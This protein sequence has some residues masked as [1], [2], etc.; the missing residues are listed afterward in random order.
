MERIDERDFYPE[1]MEGGK[2]DEVRFCKYYLRDNPMVYVDGSF[3]DVEGRI[4]D[5]SEIRR[6]I[7]LEISGFVRSGIARK[8]EAILGTMRY[9]CG[10]TKL[11]NPLK[12][13]HVKNGT[14]YLDWKFYESKQICRCRLPVEFHEDAPSPECWLRFVNEL[15]EPEDVLTLQE[16][17]GYCLIPTTVAQKM[18]IITGRGGEGKSRIG[19]VMKALLGDNMV[20]SSVSKLETSQF[21]RADLQHMLVMVDDDMNL[22]ALPTT[23][24]IKT[25]ITAES[26]MDLERKGVQSY[27]GM[28]YAR[29]MAFGNGNLRSDHDRSHGFFRRQIILNAKPKD[30]GRVDDPFL[31]DKLKAELSGIFLWCLEGLYRLIGQNFN[32]TLSEAAHNNY[33]E[34]VSESSNLKDFMTSQGYIR[35]DADACATSRSLYGAYRDWCEDNALTPM[36]QRSFSSQLKQDAALYGLRYENSVPDGPDRRVRGFYGVCTESGT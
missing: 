35:L 6:R 24:Y 23:N 1:W 7:Y 31:A 8:V 30:P 27:Q 3:F 32:F 26:P 34:A 10:G 15:L 21:A 19:V 33:E 28:L 20:Q 16:F 17:M 11:S 36:G 25:I 14:L 22:T 29:I 5:E 9:A 4:P 18:L 12:V 13:L 2:L